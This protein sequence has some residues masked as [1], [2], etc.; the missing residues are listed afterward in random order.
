MPYFP[1]D[2]PD[3]DAYSSFMATKATKS[4]ER[5][6]LCP[7]SKKA[8][9]VPILPPWHCVQL[10]CDKESTSLGDTHPHIET[11]TR[12][13]TNGDPSTNSNDGRCDMSLN[14]HNISFEGFISRTCQMLSCYLNEIHG[15]DLL[16]FP[17]SPDKKSF[18]DVIIDG[19]KHG[20]KLNGPSQMNCERKLCFVRVLLNAYREGSFEEG[21]VVCAPRLSD[22]SVWTSR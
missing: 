5:A 11:G 18:S 3:T 6:K 8:L 10:A 14:D 9:R 15:N 7:P 22:I 17:K 1:L 13:V 19:A 2:F 21:A 4:D 16:L 20:W 12:D